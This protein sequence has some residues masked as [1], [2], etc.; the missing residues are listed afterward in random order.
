MI[1]FLAKVFQEQDHANEFISGRLFANRLSYFKRVEDAEGRGDPREGAIL[2]PLDRLTI[3]LEGKDPR[4]GSVE[5]ITITGHDLEAPPVIVPRWFDHINLFC[6]YA[7]HS[8]GLH[9]ISLDNL[10]DLRKQVEI[11]ESYAKLGKHAVVIIDNPEFIRR[12]KVAAQRE[13]YGICCALVSYYDPD[14]GTAPVRSQLETIFTKSK[15]FE[16]QREFRLAINTGSLG[17][18][19]IVLDIGQIDDI[20]VPMDIFDINQKLSFRIEQQ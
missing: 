15:V 4:T 9:G 19:P 11:P 3:T 13:G 16:Y 1:F 20:A 8:G 18:E 12:V 7:A 6:M 14:V 17:C 5:E 2:P 10:R